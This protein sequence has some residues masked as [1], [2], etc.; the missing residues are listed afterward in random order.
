MKIPMNRVRTFIATLLVSAALVPISGVDST[1]EHD[2]SG[3]VV[4]SSLESTGQKNFVGPSALSMLFTQNALDREIPVA[5]RPIMGVWLI[6]IL[7]LQSL[8]SPK[9]TPSRGFVGQKVHYLKDRL[10]DY[11]GI[12]L[13]VAFERIKHEGPRK[14][15]LGILGLVLLGLYG[16]KKSADHYKLISSIKSFDLSDSR[17]VLSQDAFFLWNYKGRIALGLAGTAAL[18]LLIKSALNL[19]IIE[20]FRRSLTQ[21]QKEII[22]SDETLRELLDNAHENPAALIDHNHFTSQ[23]QEHQKELLDKAVQKYKSEA[24]PMSLFDDI[25]MDDQDL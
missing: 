3:E 16:A 5:L 8:E 21:Q 10:V 1:P 4:Q 13:Y 7:A 12:P 14:E 17:K 11:V 15:D 2:S 18:A 25:V 9:N 23:L 20:R 24:D 6:S 19:P 22:S